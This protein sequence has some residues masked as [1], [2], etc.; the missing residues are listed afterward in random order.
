[1]KKNIMKVEKINIAELITISTTNSTKLTNNIV[2]KNDLDNMSKAVS[3]EKNGMYGKSGMNAIN[4]KH[5]LMYD[6][7]HNLETDFPSKTAALQYINM[8]RPTGLDKAIQNKTEYKGHY[9]D[10]L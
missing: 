6:L 8:K 3:G 9:W 5:V 2:Y 7:E 4:G 1:M 10:L